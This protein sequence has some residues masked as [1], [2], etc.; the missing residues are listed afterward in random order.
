MEMNSRNSKTTLI[1]RANYFSAILMLILAPV[2]YYLLD[3]QAVIPVC[4]SLY[5]IVIL[6]NTLFFYRHRNLT[7]T[8]IITTVSALIGSLVVT[9]YSGGINSPFIFVL[10]LIVFAGYMATRAYGVIHF[11]LITLLIILTYLLTFFDIHFENAVPERYRS[12]F[13]LIS[14]LFSVY[15]LGG[16]FG[17]VMLGSYHNLYES[18][19]ELEKQSLQKEVLLKEIHHRVK[20]NLQTVSSLLSLQS[21]GTE[22]GDARNILQNSKNRVISMAMIHEMLYAY[23]DI[24]RIHY[25]DYVTQ[26]AEYLVRSYKGYQ[27]NINLRIEIPDVRLNIDTAIPLGLLIN[28]FITNTLKH[29]FE[30]EQAGE[31]CICLDKL[32]NGAYLLE[33]TDDGKGFDREN[34]N[35]SRRSL[36]LKLIDSLVRQ[37]N[38]KISYP[39]KE[40][41]VT[42]QIVFTETRSQTKQAGETF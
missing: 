2:C 31:I 38:G 39:E 24:S 15:I 27:H 36:G 9:L 21:R 8:Y 6:V 33:L 41:G 18:K 16:I 42:Y 25:G 28:E 23:D 29:G 26:L 11:Y 22:H 34:L 12:I 14:I 40:R 10:A 19:K 37:L 5:G 17:K 30:E 13:S 20:N 4:F 32:D 7:M 1:L 3:F 35:V